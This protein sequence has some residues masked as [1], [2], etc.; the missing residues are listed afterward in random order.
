MADI[1]V[2]IAEKTVTTVLPTD[3]EIK[4]LMSRMKTE[5][6]D[7]S[8]LDGYVKKVEIVAP[9]SLPVVNEANVPYI[10]IA[11]VSS[12]EAWKTNKKKEV[13]YTVEVYAVYWL[14]IQETAIIGGGGHTGLL[15]FVRDVSTVLR[16]NTFNDYLSKPADITV[17]EFTTAGY[18]DTIYL[19]VCTIVLTGSRIFEV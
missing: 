12:P 13:I 19:I 15:D 14:Q 1:Q 9:R 11:P 10:G 16:G 4:T 18:G 3:N 6:Q 5:L 7:D 17:P 8:T 2:I